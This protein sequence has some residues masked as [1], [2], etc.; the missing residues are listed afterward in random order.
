MKNQDNGNIAATSVVAAVTGAI[1]GAGVVAAG[2]M[3]LKDKKNQK[4]LLDT[5]EE[6]KKVA[7]L[8]KEAKD[9]VKKIWNE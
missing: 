9:E 3:A 7:G 6:V 2:A 1:I 5:K 8:A 4:K